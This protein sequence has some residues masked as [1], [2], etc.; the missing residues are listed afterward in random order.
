MIYIYITYVLSRLERVRK[1]GSMG[2]KTQEGNREG[3]SRCICIWV[4]I[5]NGHL[6]KYSMRS[7]NLKD[8]YNTSHAQPIS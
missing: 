4:P 3:W 1:N 8:L 7:I 2:I 6:H 5:P